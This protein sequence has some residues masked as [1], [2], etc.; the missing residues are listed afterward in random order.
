MP[1]T[2]DEYTVEFNADPAN[3]DAVDWKP[4]EVKAFVRPFSAAALVPVGIENIVDVH[5]DSDGLLARGPANI[6]DAYFAKFEVNIDRDKL[7]QLDENAA[8]SLVTLRVKINPSQSMLGPALIPVPG[9]TQALSAAGPKEVEGNVKVKVEFP[10][11]YIWHP[12]LK[13]A[14]APNVMIMGSENSIL[15]S[16]DFLLV[17][18]QSEEACSCKWEFRKFVPSRY[19]PGQSG[20][21]AVDDELCQAQLKLTAD[22][23]KKAVQIKEIK[24]REVLLET[25]RLIVGKD[26]EPI[27]TL[28]LTRQ[29]DKK[30]AAKNDP[31]TIDVK[32]KGYEVEVAI[33]LL[34][35]NSKAEPF[36][37]IRKIRAEDL[38]L[39]WTHL[40]GGVTGRVQWKIID[41]LPRMQKSGFR[42]LRE[43]R[44]GIGSF[45]LI[46]LSQVEAQGGRKTGV[47]LQLIDE[48]ITKDTLELTG[49]PDTT[50][51]ELDVDERLKWEER[52]KHWPSEIKGPEAFRALGKAIAAEKRFKSKFCDIERAQYV[53]DRVRKAAAV[54]QLRANTDF[55]APT[56]AKDRPDFAG[57]QAGFITG[58]ITGAKLAWPAGPLVAVGAA[59]AGGVVGAV[60]G[61]MA[62]EAY[63]KK[64][65]DPENAGSLKGGPGARGNCGEWS[66]AFQSVLIG[67]GMPQAQV[68]YG[69]NDPTPGQPPSFTKGTMSFGGTDTAV[70]LRDTYPA[71]HGVV[72]AERIFDMFRQ[73]FEVS[74]NDPARA[75]EW[76][77]LPPTVS[78][79]NRSF[80]PQR[81]WLGGV[82]MVDDKGQPIGITK[83]YIK[84]VDHIVIYKRPDAPEPPSP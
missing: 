66:Y 75:S 38:K 76:A 72:N 20:Y 26:E 57:G 15:E 46:D 62:G 5:D 25:K 51:V 74:Q 27:G 31:A 67:A 30:P 11:P 56:Q 10:P 52:P 60:A 80:G 40:S 2:K 7:S 32:V 70:L 63:D 22:D 39:Y 43:Q 12:Y 33:K 82:V 50:G 41:E 18:S 81:Y 78:Q 64:Y 45:P 79:V 49:E 1:N 6:A 73:M 19:S 34:A 24:P 61:S 55:S 4:C 37:I 3:L 17:D 36:T 16:R 83:K 59:L 21:T 23:W 54:Y 65:G 9:V 35:A 77:N 48:P 42:N 29:T 8:P 47:Q 13:T 69:T 68:V 84:N 28:E 53:F 58:G 71:A 14:N 44:P